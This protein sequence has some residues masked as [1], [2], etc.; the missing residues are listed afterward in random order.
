ME[1]REHWSSNIRRPS[2]E[3][4]ILDAHCV[5]CS[6][7]SWL[8]SPASYTYNVPGDLPRDLAAI[9][10]Q[11]RIFQD[12]NQRPGTPDERR[13][14]LIHRLVSCAVTS[15]YVQNNWPMWPVH[16]NT[17]FLCESYHIQTRILRL[18]LLNWK[19]PIVQCF[20][21]LYIAIHFEKKTENKTKRIKKVC[22]AT[23][24]CR[25]ILCWDSLFL[26]AAYL[27]KTCWVISTFVLSRHACRMSFER[28]AEG[29]RSGE[30]GWRPWPTPKIS[31]RICI[32]RW[33]TDQWAH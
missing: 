6:G 10:S 21:V 16:I 20:R 24:I 33:P 30:W 27:R 13:P 5:T 25:S 31:A 7:R 9:S 32:P 3:V 1:P 22:C 8:L 14:L 15:V 28:F 18:F 4:H 26:I 11:D 23:D 19:P 17:H 29:G 12:V 2:E